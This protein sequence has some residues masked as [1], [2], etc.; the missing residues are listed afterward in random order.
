LDL[1]NCQGYE[2]SAE[3]KITTRVWE[4]LPFATHEA[5]DPDPTPGRELPALLASSLPRVFIG[6][7]LPFI[8][9]IYDRRLRLMTVVRD[10]TPEQI[11]Y[12]VREHIRRMDRLWESLSDEDRNP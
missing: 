12:D 11:F 6:W 2:T 8:K 5:V 1:L 7:E 3:E 10:G 4:G 9:E